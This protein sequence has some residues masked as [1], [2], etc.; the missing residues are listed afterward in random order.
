MSNLKPLSVMVQKLWPR[1]QV[2]FGTESPTGKKLDAAEF[3]SGDIKIQSSQSIKS[4]P[5]S[6]INT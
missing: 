2:F 3:H 5:E 4:D 6:S 1:L